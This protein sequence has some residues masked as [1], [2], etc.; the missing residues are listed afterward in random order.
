MSQTFK[1]IFIL[2]ING[3]FGN[4]N[5]MQAAMLARDARAKMVIPCH[6]WMFA[7]HGG[8]PAQFMDACKEYAPGARPLL[9]S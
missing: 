9:M 5:D 2:P 1:V 4:L 6:Y 7:E 8:S 3:A